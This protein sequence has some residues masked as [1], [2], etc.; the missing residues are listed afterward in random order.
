MDVRNCNANGTTR[1]GY[2]SKRIEGDFCQIF[3]SKGKG[4]GN[5]GGRFESVWKEG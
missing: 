4:E 2:G 5:L 1:L 3:G